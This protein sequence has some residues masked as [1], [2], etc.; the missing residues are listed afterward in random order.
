[1]KKLILK[2]LV[3]G[4]I[5]AGVTVA[6]ILI[7][8][9][10]APLQISYDLLSKALTADGEQTTMERN[11]AKPEIQAICGDYKILIEGEF[12]LI[13]NSYLKLPLIETD[14]D[15]SSVL[16]ATNN[17]ISAVKDTN[18]KID[19]YMNYV[20]G[21]NTAEV[22]LQNFLTEVKNMVV[23]QL[24]AADILNARLLACLDE[25]YYKGVYDYDFAM[26]RL[27]YAYSKYYLTNYE[28]ENAATIKGILVKVS[29]ANVVATKTEVAKNLPAMATDFV[30]SAPNIDIYQ[31]IS[32]TEYKGG[33]SAE[34]LAH[35][36][37]IE[38]F[39]SG[40]IA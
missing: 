38:A 14:K 1:M 2:L 4:L 25:S 36:E 39:I 34:N 17:Y 19:V 12:N 28:A 7:F 26:N 33:L 16:E 29:A 20:S 6:V 5:I 27:Q 8:F 24:E 9:Q 10:K 31:L 37:K 18:H 22:T 15:Y 21:G 11:I 35:T 30:N 3:S 23:E 40:V 13:L 32:N